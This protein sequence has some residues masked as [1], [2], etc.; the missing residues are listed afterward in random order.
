MTGTPAVAGTVGGVDEDRAAPP[1]QDEIIE[2]IEQ[3]FARLFTVVKASLREAAAVLGPD[4]QPAAWTVLRYVVRAAPTQPGPIAVATGMDKSAVSRQLRE[5]RERGLITVE[6]ST[7]D[8]RAMLVRPTEDGS[9]RVASVR[10]EWS[11]RFR[12]LLG[13]WSEDELTTFAVLLDRFTVD[14]P[15]TPRGDPAS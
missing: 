6:P 9:R 7:S 12:E 5:L 14:G 11:R 2:S 10:D 4:V 3:S 15:W 8:A 1:T 13:T